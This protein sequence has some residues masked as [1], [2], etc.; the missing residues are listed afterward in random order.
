[1]N[2]TPAFAIVLTTPLPCLLDASVASFYDT[3]AQ[4]ALTIRARFKMDAF[5]KS[6]PARNTV[7]TPGNPGV[8]DPRHCHIV[9]EDNECNSSQNLGSDDEF[10]ALYAAAT[11]SQG[12]GRSPHGKTRGVGSTTVVVAVDGKDQQGQQ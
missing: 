2:I 3:T 11:K 12:Q 9:E 1:L 10:E 8:V 7:L 5:L 4:A 6:L